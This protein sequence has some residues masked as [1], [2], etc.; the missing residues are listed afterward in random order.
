VE[1]EG[2]LES[3]F[4]RTEELRAKYGEELKRMIM[5]A[6]RQG[7][8]V[9]AMICITPTGEIK[10]SRTCWGLRHKVEVS[11]CKEGNL[12]QFGS[13]HVHLGGTGVFSVPDLNQAIHREQFSCVGYMK[14][15]IPVIK[16]INPQI[17]RSLSPSQRAE[18]R[19]MLTQAEQNIA[20]A[21]FL[22]RTNPYNPQVKALSQRAQE[23]LAKVERLFDAYEV[24]LLNWSS[25]QVALVTTISKSCEVEP[26]HPD[27]AKYVPGMPKETYVCTVRKG[28]AGRDIGRPEW[29][30]VATIDYNYQPN[31]KVGYIE[32]I[33]VWEEFQRRG[34]GKLLVNSAIEDMRYYGIEKVYTAPVKPSSPAFFSALGFKPYGIT[35]LYYKEL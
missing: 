25:P 8:E 22:Y 13:F 35:P 23:I 10:L 5:E 4:T 9:G 19:R 17:Y 30:Y 14:N 20:Y 7:R 33:L 1:T 29:G 24:E 6:E 11:D 31:E 28:I 32:Y 12:K 27:L 21:Q 18:I 3:T 16:C 2:S 26:P 34:Y 15:G